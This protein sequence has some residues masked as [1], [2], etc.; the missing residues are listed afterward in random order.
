MPAQGFVPI[1]RVV[2]EP[3]V[4]EQDTIADG[5][6]IT[7]SAN[8]EKYVDYL[9]PQDLHL[10]E[11]IVLWKN[12]ESGDRTW[13]SLINPAGDG[14]PA[15]NP[16]GSTIDVG[17]SLSPYYN[18][19]AG[20]EAVEVYNTDQTALLEVVPIQSISGSVVT[21]TK[22]LAG[23][24]TTANKIR[25]RIQSFNPV[26]GSNGRGGGF[27]FLGDG[28]R[29]IGAPNEQTAKLPKGLIFNVGLDLVSGGSTRGFCVNFVFRKPVA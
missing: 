10:D 2:I 7:A 27:F 12:F 14:N 4:G 15:Q 28:F 5:L 20:A 19:A 11:L 22:A 17:T 16:S 25:V 18:P 13:L 9:M 23:T 3:R 6:S 24:Y 29:P 21:L 26:R 8:T 1:N